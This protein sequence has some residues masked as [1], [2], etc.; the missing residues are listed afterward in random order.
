MDLHL[1]FL[2]WSRCCLAY[3][4]V[5]DESRRNQVLRLLTDDRLIAKLKISRLANPGDANSLPK[6]LTL[7]SLRGDGF[8][9]FN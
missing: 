1:Y 8:Q 2:I 3:S 9:T 5:N 7:T 6:V 4:T